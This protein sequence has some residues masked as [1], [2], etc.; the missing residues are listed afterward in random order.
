[1]AKGRRRHETRGSHRDESAGRAPVRSL[2]SPHPL[3]S[4]LALALVVL[5]AH[6]WLIGRYAADVPWLDQ[7]DAEAQGLYQPWRAGTLDFQSWFAPHNEHRIFFTRVLSMGLLRLNGQWD[8]RL[9][10]VANAGLYAVIL[11]G[12]FLVLRR[13]RTPA[14]QI[15][16]WLLL[17]VIGSAPYGAT[18]TLLGFQSQFYFLTGFSLLAIYGLINSS[19]GSFSW[20]A[21][22]IGGCAALV[23]MG[24]GYAAAVAVLGLLFCAALRAG[25]GFTQELRRRRVAGV[26]ACALVAAGVLLRYSPPQNAAFAAKSVADFCGFLLACLSWPGKPMILLA[27]ISWAPFALFLANYLR[28]QTPDEPAERFI[29]AIGFWVLLQ[30]VALA[31]YRANSGEGLESRY[32]DILA[33][34]LLANAL[35]TIWLLGGA[36]NLRRFAPVLAI[37]WLI[38]NAIGLYGASFDG[39]ALAWKQAMEIRRAATAGFVAAG[40]QR[41]LE[42]A[43][44]HPDVPRLA[45]LL[46]APAIRPILPVGVRAS[47]P[48]TPRNASPAPELLNGV[49]MPNLA[50][51]SPGVWTSP[52][53]FSRFAVVPPSTRFEY[54]VRTSGSLPFLL[55]YILGNGYDLSVVDS[56][57][58]R[59]A[60]VPLPGDPDD[61]GHHAFVAC[62]AGECVLQGSGGA[63]QV[64]IMEPKEIGV[65]SIAA[66][67]AGWAG[68][69]VMVAGLV[70][71]LAVMA[72]S[73]TRRPRYADAAVRS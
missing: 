73:A 34:G 5:G 49:S 56:R 40:D 35:C 25:Q 53:M 22:V 51:V 48:L 37:L 62:P 29:L 58:A 64:A 7:W 28:K 38:V 33:F 10:M 50:D 26:A 32:A 39:S 42:R 63:S 4:A 55:L 46:S 61:Q 65:L 20:V 31:I 43:P 9:Q 13:N 67:M 8:P 41:Y 69:I 68:P 45:A 24:S 44:A 36:G 3:L 14:F 47:L 18:N 72:V 60:V 17:A 1:M 16:C 59:H 6:W 70:M 27:V 57:H 21:G 71:F 19:P 11:A 23:S 30:A 52:G 2:P 15:S 54:G 12:L 66:L